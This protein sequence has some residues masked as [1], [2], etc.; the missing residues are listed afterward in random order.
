[1]QKV[2]NKPTVRLQRPSDT[3]WLSLG[4]AVTALLKSLAAVKAVLENEAA[5]GNVTI[6]LVH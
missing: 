5:S 4:N 1:M 6:G 2:M 3:R